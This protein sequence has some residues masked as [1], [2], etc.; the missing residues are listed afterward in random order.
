MVVKFLG[1]L[2]SVQQT[3]RYDGFEDVYFTAR[4]LCHDLVQSERSMRKVDD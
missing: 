3:I 1:H 4:C 2:R